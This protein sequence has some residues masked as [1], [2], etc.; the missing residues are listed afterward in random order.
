MARKRKGNG[1]AAENPD[2]RQ[3]D[4]AYVAWM[5]AE[6]AVG[7]P[8][9][10]P[11]HNVQSHARNAA[12]SHTTH[13]PNRGPVSNGYDSDETYPE[14]DTDDEED[15]AA[16]DGDDPVAAWHGAVEYSGP[17]E[18]PSS[19]TTA[20]ATANPLGKDKRPGKAPTPSKARGGKTFSPQKGARPEWSPKESTILVAARWFTKDELQQMTGKQGSQ[21][22][23]QLIEHI[24]LQH[25]DWS[26]NEA[27][28]TN[29]WKRLKALWKQIDKGDNASGG[30]TVIKPPWWEWMVLYYKDTA[31]AEPHALDG[32]GADDVTVD[33]A[34]KITTPNKAD[35]TATAMRGTPPSARRRINETATM[36]AAQLLSS[37][38]KECSE[39][40]VAQITGVIREWMAT[41][42]SQ[43]SRVLHYSAARRVDDDDWPHDTAGP[44][45]STFSDGV[46]EW[47]RG[48]TS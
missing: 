39:A 29:Q 24:K 4:L 13:R 42:Q 37:T 25:P 33:P 43:T 9:T 10:K 22:W 2:W 47:R 11:L 1:D 27:A 34:V 35:A 48:D 19:T 12:H 20:R 16:S 41:Q 28:C 14:K 6:I 44:G 40:G 31:A 32:G 7:R 3:E 46:E 38:L 17:V 8:S 23:L 36:A 5:N 26:H 15:E 18:G 21:Y 45:G 30:G